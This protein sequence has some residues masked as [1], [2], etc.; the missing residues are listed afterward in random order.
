M[1]NATPDGGGK[2]M[3]DRNASDLRRITL[4]ILLWLVTTAQLH[5]YDRTL[6]LLLLLLLLG[7]R[8]TFVL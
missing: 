3:K 6:L 5:I 8:I 2:D 4:L 7:S 1:Q